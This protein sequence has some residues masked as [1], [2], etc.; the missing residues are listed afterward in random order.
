MGYRSANV[1]S[2]KRI[3]G[4]N[5]AWR[6][7]GRGTRSC[8]CKCFIIVIGSLLCCINRGVSFYAAFC[9]CPTYIVGT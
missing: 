9:A 5:D 1:A 2:R 4:S 7:R 6:G 8:C 3:F